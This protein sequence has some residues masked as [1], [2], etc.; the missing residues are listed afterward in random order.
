MVVK[1]F[2]GMIDSSLGNDAQDTISLHTNDGSTGYRIVKMEIFPNQ[3]G[4]I[5]TEGTLKVFKVKQSTVDALVDFTDNTLLAAAY[6][7]QNDGPNTTAN[8]VISIFDNEVFNQD[9]YVVYDEIGGTQQ[10][11]NYYIELEQI[12]LD[13]NQNTVATLKDIRNIKSG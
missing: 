6:Y 8:T 9:I 3:P 7:T 1:S 2:R 13:L 5:D 4:A 11:M 12:K 10:K